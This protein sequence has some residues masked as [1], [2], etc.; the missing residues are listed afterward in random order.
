MERKSK[1]WR[2]IRDASIY[3][4]CLVLMGWG[5]YTVMSPLA[6][7]FFEKRER[8][9]AIRE[10]R[11]QFVDNHGDDSEGAETNPTEAGSQETEPE[12]TER[13][14]PELWEALTQYNEDLFTQG[15]S[16]LQDPFAYAETVVN[17]KDYGYTEKVFG[18]CMIP[19]LDVE[20]PLYLGAT[21]GNMKKGAAQMTVT[22]MPIGG[23]NTNTVLAIH[24]NFV[25]EV[26]DIKKG[27]EILIQNPWETM[28]Y[29]VAQIELIW[30]YET[31]KVLI[32]PG[33][34]LVTI[35]TCHPW[36][37]GGKYR[38]LVIAERSE[39]E[40][41]EEGTE[42]I[43]EDTRP[44][45]SFG[46]SII[47]WQDVPDGLEISNGIEFASSK[48]DLFIKRTLPMI[49]VGTILLLIVALIMLKIVFAIKKRVSRVRGKYE[50]R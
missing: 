16:H 43:P 2:R 14:W 35:M 20:L 36:G 32:Q 26:E 3:T 8:Q 4:F 11:V 25:M 27:D 37:S 19:S 42:T 30:P 18:I 50:R 38:Y 44:K 9:G 31:E 45:K 15:Q 47:A 5:L 10:Y 28:R 12:K 1:V 21:N 48:M 17:P 33:R 46:E 13:K 6:K 39:K 41:S 7:E 24:R 49:C 22:S 34:E 23:N 40:L 29:E